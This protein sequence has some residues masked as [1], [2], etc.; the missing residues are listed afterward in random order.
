MSTGLGTLLLADARLPVGGHTYSAGLEPALLDGMPSDR[1][2]DY[3]AARTRTVGLVE[4]A[5]SVLAH[6]AVGGAA[7][8]GPT[9]D[10]PEGVGVDAG[11]LADVHEALL[12]RSPSEP[13]RDISGL[14]GRGLV[15]LA[16]RLWPEHPAVK[17]LR[18]LGRA[19]QRPIALGVVAAVMGPDEAEVARVSLYDDAQTVASAALKLAPVDPVEAAGW[20]LGAEGVISA[21]VAEALAVRGPDDLPARTAP[22]IEG[23][24][25]EH[26]LKTRRI[27]VA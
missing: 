5:A 15:R 22:Q 4:A 26:Q 8:P 11:A 24:S 18:T 21:S 13:L 17:A 27:F 25:L 2:A 6:R 1:I 20:V 19:P 10:G 7:A 12:A 3:I 9:T 23:W 16:D 14:L